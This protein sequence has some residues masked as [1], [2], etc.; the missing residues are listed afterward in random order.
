MVL[1]VVQFVGTAR[2]EQVPLVKQVLFWQVAHALADAQLEQLF[3]QLP[4]VPVILL[5][6]NPPTQAEQPVV[7]ALQVVQLI[8]AGL[9]HLLFAP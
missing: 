7:F 4:H 1:Q 2:V 8:V 6:Q 5:S 9:A 3:P